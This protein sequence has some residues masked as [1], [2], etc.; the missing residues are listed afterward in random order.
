MRTDGRTGMTKPVVAFR[1]FAT[2]PK[3]EDVSIGGKFV[4]VRDPRVS[5]RYDVSSAVSAPF[6]R[7]YVL[8]LI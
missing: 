2:T 6:F 4:T 1:N 7:F 3:I 5:N 8:P